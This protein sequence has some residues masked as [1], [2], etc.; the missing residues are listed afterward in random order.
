[1]RQ[2]RGRRSRAWYRRRGR[3]LF[4]RFMGIFG[5]VALLAI[6]SVIALAILVTALVGGSSGIAPGVWV[7]SGVISLSLPLLGWAL[8][9]Y[10]LREITRPL[11]DIVDAAD[12][13]AD[14][15]LT[16]RLNTRRGPFGRLGRTFN[17]MVEELERSERQR[18]NLTAD[19]AHELRTPLHVIQG[20]LEGVLDGVYAPDADHVNA[21]LDETRLLA[22][23][24]DDLNTLSAAESGHLALHLTTV[25]PADLLEDAATS[26][27]GQADAAEVTIHTTVDPMLE[28]TSVTAD[29]G[30][31]AQ[32]LGNLVMNALRYTPAEGRIDLE[33][34]RIDE[35][36]RLTI[37]DTGSGIPAKDLP[38][39]FDRFWRGDRART[40]SNGTGGGLGLAIVRQLVTLHGGEI[41]VD[42][43]V[44]SG[45]TFTIDL[46]I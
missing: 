39:I 31:L 37:A 2:H 19:V 1:M 15:D 16:I 38:Y 7:I 41:S 20:N 42:S 18:R 8:A 45:T 40:H 22:R 27:S 13:V 26:Y 17:R 34:K 9:A 44:G 10:A 29:P 43:K 21:T 35:G 12:A 24:V 36:I 32:V 30:R 46:P 5:L 33:A 25:N 23:L 14:G 28:G 6:G 4:L 3:G 11:S